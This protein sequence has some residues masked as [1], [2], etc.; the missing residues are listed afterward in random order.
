MR[1]A[2]FQSALYFSRRYSKAFL[3]SNS[4]MPPTPELQR[5]LS[6][7]SRSNS[8]N[9]SS[10]S[11]SSS[12]SANQQ[13]GGN[14]KRRICS[15]R[16]NQAVDL[17]PVYLADARA[18]ETYSEACPEGAL[19]LGVAE[20]L[21]LEDLLMPVLKDPKMMSDA[22]G[23]DCIYYQPTAG[24]EGLRQAMAAYIEETVGLEKGRLD[25]DGLVIGAGC[26]AVLENLCFCLADRGDAVMIPTPYYAA[27]EFDLVARAGMT[28]QP[29]NTLEYQDKSS[30]EQS[31]SSSN[32]MI[33][34]EQYYPNRAS[35]EAAYH[36]AQESGHTPRILLLS[37]PMN[38]LGI[39]YPPAVIQDCIDFCRSREVHLISDEIYMGSVHQPASANFESTLKLA[40]TGPAGL[41]PFVHWVYALSKDFCL[42]G[43][44]V[45]AAYT[46]NEE[47]RVPLQKLNDLCQVSSPTQ[48]WTEQVMK[49]LSDENPQETWTASFRRENHKRLSK[50]SSALT[51]TLDDC[52]IPYLEPTAGL[53]C[54][55]DL[56]EFLPSDLSMSPGDRERQLYLEMVN[57]FGLLFTPGWS[58]RNEKPGF[59]RCVFTAATQEEFTLSLERFRKFAA[60]KRQ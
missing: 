4:I 12:S 5:F 23:P 42:S 60:A 14:G 32:S 45:G 15:P 46:E 30:K 54:W 37:H 19:Q 6:T 7:S 22:I 24:R 26:N 28:I 3:T 59:F 31:N 11:R 18:V 13:H 50:R 27:F 29:V 57:E 34:P 44:R 53:F 56:S 39:C 8:I 2:S 55:M 51:A 58:M 43:L 9:S 10:S 20:S 25:T 38:P 35:L 16:A 47:I 17:L 40:D 1:I 48:V 41:G 52:Q 33:N 21:L 36:L 49:R